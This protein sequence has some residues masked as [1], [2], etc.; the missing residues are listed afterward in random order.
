MCTHLELQ[1]ISTGTG[2][3]LHGGGDWKV[4]PLQVVGPADLEG[5]MPPLCQVYPTKLI[6]YISESVVFP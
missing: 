4:P 1:A 5:A 2:L 6:V 3:C